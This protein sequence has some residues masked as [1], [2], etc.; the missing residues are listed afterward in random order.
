MASVAA[1]I[2]LLSFTN[3]PLNDKHVSLRERE[4]MMQEFEEP[5]SQEVSI[6]RFW[7]R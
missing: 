3:D 7:K 2:L 1:I 5:P 6:H 4:Y